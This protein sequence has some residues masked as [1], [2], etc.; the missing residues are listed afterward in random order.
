MAKTKIDDL[1]QD[2]EELGPDQQKA[3]KGG[4]LPVVAVQ[5]G[6]VG[7]ATVRAGGA[8]AMLAGAAAIFA[9]QRRAA[10]VADLQSAGEP[11]QSQDNPLYE[12]AQPKKPLS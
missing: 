12:G 9:T 5:A 7:S 3:V 11:S 8:P 4:A 2:T 10:P 1:A 6:A